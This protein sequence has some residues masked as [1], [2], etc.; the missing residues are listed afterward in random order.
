MI[1]KSNVRKRYVIIIY[2][3]INMMFQ[4]EYAKNRII[5]ERDRQIERKREKE[6]KKDGNSFL[7]F[8][9]RKRQVKINSSVSFPSLPL[10]STHSSVLMILG[11][12]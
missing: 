5:I 10:P 2:N 7:T 4:I 8:W 3:T 1:E 12:K 11:I 6:K 9:Q